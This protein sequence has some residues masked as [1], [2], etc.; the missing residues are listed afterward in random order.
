MSMFT[1]EPAVMRPPVAEATCCPVVELR[2]YTLHAGR[3]DELLA[4]F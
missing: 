4:L 1:A 3:R 2:Q